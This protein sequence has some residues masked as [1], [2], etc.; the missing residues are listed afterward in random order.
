MPSRRRAWVPFATWLMVL[1]AVAYGAADRHLLLWR[2]DGAVLRPPRAG[3]LRVATWNLRN[4]PRDHDRAWM[5]AQLRKARPD[6]LAL[7]EI[8]DPT[9]LDDLL[10]GYEVH[11][12][13]HGGRN[14]QRL[15]IAFRPGRVRL[16]EGL[17][18]HPALSLDGRVRPAVSAR[19]EPRDGGPP[20]SIVVV[21]LKATPAGFTERIQQWEAL[22]QLVAGLPDPR[23]LVLGDFNATGPPAGSPLLELG[24]LE[25]RLH[26][27]GLRR[28][29]T[30]GGCTAYWGGVRFDAWV[31]PSELDLVFA[32]EAWLGDADVAAVPLTH[33][34]AHACR[35]FR[36]TD[37][38]PEQSYARAS[39]HCPV[40][41]DLPSA[42][43]ASR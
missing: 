43:R 20:F 3:A 42:V 5:R 9:G 8:L 19:L 26:G 13:Q 39:D 16:R 2:G 25:A 6:V 36:T 12:S 27:V 33:C 21:H 28:L 32:S 37:A 34:A 7:Q 23:V 10:P 41:A 4:F 38:E 22:R 31:E 1:L 40:V 15:G 30:L 35:A 29:P 24:V 11:L 14:Q 18:E 17:R